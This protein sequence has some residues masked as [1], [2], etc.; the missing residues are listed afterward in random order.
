MSYHAARIPAERGAP[1][2]FTFHGTGGDQHQ[3]HDLGRRMVPH[4]AVVSPRG[5]VNEMGHLRFFRRL[6]EG[7]YDMEDLGRR[8]EAMAAFLAAEKAEAAPSRTIG[9]GYSN[10]A[11]ILAATA[12]RHPDIVDELVLMHPLIPH[13]PEPQ[14]GFADRRILITAGRNDRICPAERTEELSDWFEE[15]GADVI[16]HWH[17]GGH[18]LREDELM[19]AHA[20]LN[21]R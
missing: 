19:A 10:G 6:G 12:F 2:V 13:S 16:L 1:L 8:V 21:R 11:N 14:P 3:L 17:E 20:F 15:Q 7:V 18:E 5:D 9:I 4:S